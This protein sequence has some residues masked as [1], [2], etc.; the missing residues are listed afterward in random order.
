MKASWW[1]CI[2][3]SLDILFFSYDTGFRQTFAGFLFY[4]YEIISVTMEIEWSN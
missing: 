2:G 3:F 1:I 4:K